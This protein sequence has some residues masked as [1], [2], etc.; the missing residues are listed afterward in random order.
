M[1]MEIQRCG[2]FLYVHSHNRGT[3]IPVRYRTYTET[4][5]RLGPEMD[6]S[7]SGLCYVHVHM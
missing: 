7:M 6:E 5:N 4:V 1:R 2:I 3:T